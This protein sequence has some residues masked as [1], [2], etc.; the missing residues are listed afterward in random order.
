MRTASL[1]VHTLAKTGGS[2]KGH[3]ESGPARL[4][5]LSGPHQKKTP[6]QKWPGV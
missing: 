2:G 1:E 4:E 6:G 3:V 5:G